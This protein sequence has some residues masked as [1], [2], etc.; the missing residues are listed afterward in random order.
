MNSLQ[1]A[2]SWQ[3][4]M[5]FFDANEEPNSPT[6]RLNRYSVGSKAGAGDQL[7]LLAKAFGMLSVFWQV[8]F[9]LQIEQ[10]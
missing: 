7:P 2:T 6:A 10:G 3:L 9:L 1:Q 5:S 4:A 8:P